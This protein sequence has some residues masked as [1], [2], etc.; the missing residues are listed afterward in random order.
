MITE[1]TGKH[2]STLQ[3][4]STASTSSQS[5]VSENTSIT[6][7]SSL[8][9][10][11]DKGRSGK[12]SSVTFNLM[13]I[14]SSNDEDTDLSKMCE[15]FSTKIESLRGRVSIKKLI[16]TKIITIEMAYKLKSGLITMDE[17]QAS[18]AQFSGKPLSIA[19]IYLE[20]SKK[21]I[22]FMQAADAGLMAKTYAIEF[23]EAQAATGAIIDPITGGSY[24]ASEAL[25]KG[26]IDSDL[27]DKI[28]DA[29]KAVSG[30][31]HAGKLLSVFQAMEE[32][33]VDR[34][35]GKAILEAQLATG[36]L[37]HPL[38]G[39][40][41]PLENA[42]EQGLINQATYQTLYDP[43]SNP[44]S[45]HNPETRQR[46]YYG[47][48]LKLC[49]YDVNGGVY[50][51]PIG[52]SQMTSFSPANTHRVS[53]IN[54]ASGIEKS[55]YEAYKSSLIDLRIYLFLS[56]QDSDW[57][58]TTLVDAAGNPLHILI[59][60][61]SGRQFCL[62]S[63]LNL[64][65]LQTIEL[66][67]YRRGE[68]SIYELADLLISRKVVHP[69]KDS[70]IAG[71]WDVT[72]KKRLSVFRG[73]QQSLL[74]RLTAMKLLEAQV[75]TGGICDPA[76]GERVQITEALRR[77]LLDDSFIR[78]LQQFEQA[79]YGIIHPKTRKKMSV[80]QAIQE[81]LF[82]K[83][84]GFRCLEFQLA[85][86]GLIDPETG[87]RVSLEEGF[88]NSMIDKATAIHLKD[89]HSYPKNITCPKT[90][91]KISFK[92]ALEKG[93]Y[94]SHTGLLLLDATKHHSTGATSSFQYYY[95]RY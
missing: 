68:L 75:C 70:P 78:P 43:V 50:L 42:I 25:D 13:G 27:K 38:I 30:F 29:D 61:K 89:E 79:F 10:K 63:A 36:G 53:V 92:E 52:E 59:D 40:R 88:Q 84:A 56:Q 15:S 11:V 62:E 93:V 34:H 85:T 69:V 6:R 33:I 5:N 3:Q 28:I 54:S 45:F 80:G 83:D 64:R 60:K 24:S 39:M 1:N 20:S 22:S 32:R 4:F 72:F 37:I 73:L 7:K 41:V 67:R 18:L 46:A 90:K 44:K 91:R 74:D 55:A 21:K 77:G 26:I 16:K 94:D 23:L 8:S 12:T 9:D 14:E 95:Y 82:P 47:E 2:T 81:N 48:L 31:L 49:V 17:L 65:I 35:R 57:Q 71:L 86:G 51:L 87:K 58:E 76:S 66:Q 19:G